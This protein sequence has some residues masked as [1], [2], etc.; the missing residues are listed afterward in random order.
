MD[1][2]L[3]VCARACM[4]SCPCAEGDWLL[5]AAYLQ[6]AQAKV[7]NFYAW[8]SSRSHRAYAHSNRVTDA[9]IPRKFGQEGL[10]KVAVDHFGSADGMG[11]YK[12]D[13]GR[14]PELK[15]KAKSWGGFRSRWCTD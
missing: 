10:R 11:A 12:W 14:D 7:E 5:L 3:C 6:A 15:S 9:Y 1:N 8:T 13:G 2:V 4:H